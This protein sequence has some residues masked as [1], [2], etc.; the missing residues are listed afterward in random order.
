MV[1]KQAVVQNQLGIHARPATLLVQ[2]AAKFESEIYLSK[3]DVRRINGKSIMGVMMLAA[4]HG[5]EVLV[6]TD[7][8]DEVEALESVAQLLSSSFEDRT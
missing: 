6:E 4:E 3:G 2:M 8:E 1:E 7:G 5:A